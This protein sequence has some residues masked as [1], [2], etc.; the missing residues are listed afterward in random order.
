MSQT[1]QHTVPFP[2]NWAVSILD[3]NKHFACG[4]HWHNLWT[5]RLLNGCYAQNHRWSHTLLQ[6]S[7]ELFKIPHR[8]CSGLT[9]S[10][11]SKD[12]IVCDCL[13]CIRM[14]SMSHPHLLQLTTTSANLHPVHRIR[15]C[16]RNCPQEP[17][18]HNTTFTCQGRSL[19]V[20][21]IMCLSE[22]LIGLLCTV[23]NPWFC[24]RLTSEQSLDLARSQQQK[25]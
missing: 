17:P 12:L 10:R 1:T 16:C 11:R 4:E 2:C 5:W 6:P 24:A 23:I 18:C 22:L 14:T 9:K 13:L 7:Q 19:T 3:Y 15:N 8:Y 20:C 25:N 21:W